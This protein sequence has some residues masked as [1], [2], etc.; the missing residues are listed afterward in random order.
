[1]KLLKENSCF[2]NSVPIG[3]LGLRS[4]FKMWLIFVGVAYG[5]FVVFSTLCVVLGGGLLVGEFNEYDFCRWYG[6]SFGWYCDSG[7]YECCWF[8]MLKFWLSYI[9]SMYGLIS[10]TVCMRGG[11]WL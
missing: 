7:L 4:L 9:N 1:M 8:F 10:L 6:M 2:Y 11:C 5:F 3:V